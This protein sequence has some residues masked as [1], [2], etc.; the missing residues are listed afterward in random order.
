MSTDGQYIGYTI[1]KWHR[2]VAENFNRLR[3]VQER[4]RQTD[5][6]TD[7]RQHIA[8]DMNVRGRSL[9]SRPKWSPRNSK[10]KWS[11]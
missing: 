7:G 5:S 6:Q 1:T 11:L 4:Y 8:N 10:G 3:G 2:N 9:K